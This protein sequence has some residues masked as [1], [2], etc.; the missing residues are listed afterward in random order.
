MSK[1][2]KNHKENI[3]KAL[4]GK[5]PK[6]I[7]DNKGIIRTEVNKKKISDTLKRKGIRPPRPPRESLCRGSNHRW[8]KGGISSI[9]ELIRKSPEYK[10]WCKSV[11]IRDNFVCIKSWCGYEGKKIIADHIKPFALFPELRFAIDNGR[12]LCDKCHKT[13]NTCGKN[14]LGKRSRI[15]YRI[16]VAQ[17]RGGEDEKSGN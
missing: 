7:S 10:L 5:T 16:K 12:T 11:F 9:N 14:C 1:L 17:G 3:S 6:F 4:K 8:W 13:T 2:T 15:R